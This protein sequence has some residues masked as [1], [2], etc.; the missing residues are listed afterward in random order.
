VLNPT[1]SVSIY[2]NTIHGA[3]QAGEEGDYRHV[4]DGILQVRPSDRVTLAANVDYGAEADVASGDSVSDAVWWGGALYARAQLGE[5]TYLSLRIESFEDE[6]GARTGVVQRLTG[7]T[8]T[9]EFRPAQ[10]L[11]VRSDLRFDTSDEEVFED[12]RGEMV[13]KGQFTGTFQAIYL[14]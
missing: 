1:P 13:E 8:L 4:F 11:L 14:F 12:D 10:S 5:R 2:L 9:P 3:E 7:I 6:D